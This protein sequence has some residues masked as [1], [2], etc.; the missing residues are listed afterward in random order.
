MINVVDGV[1]GTTGL[2]VISAFLT[3]G[4]CEDKQNPDNELEGG[5][6]ISEPMGKWLQNL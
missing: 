2:S 1:L 4:Y 6:K 5:D 3:V